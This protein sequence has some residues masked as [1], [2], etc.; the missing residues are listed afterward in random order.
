MW[1]ILFIA[2]TVADP[3]RATLVALRDFASALE[4]VSGTRSLGI[5]LDGFAYHL[6]DPRGFPVS[7]PDQVRWLLSVP[8]R[9]HH[10]S[11]HLVGSL[12][13]L[14]NAANLYHQVLQKELN[15]LALVVIR[16]S[17]AQLEDNLSIDTLRC[18]GGDPSMIAF[19]L[20][21][22][23][24]LKAETHL[25][26]FE[27]G[28]LYRYL[29][30]NCV[31]WADRER[32]HLAIQES[33][34]RL[35]A[36]GPTFLDPAT[37]LLRSKTQTHNWFQDLEISPSRIAAIE[38]GSANEVFAQMISPTFPRAMEVTTGKR[39]QRGEGG[40]AGS[41]KRSAR[42]AASSSEAPAEFTLAT[43]ND[44]KL[45]KDGHILSN[46]ATWLKHAHVDLAVLSE[47]TTNTEM[48]SEEVGCS[49][50]SYIIR[51]PEKTGR[52]LVGGVAIMWRSTATVLEPTVT[53]PTNIHSLGM[54]TFKGVKVI[55]LYIRPGDNSDDFMI[56]ALFETMSDVAREVG[57]GPTIVTG[58][59]NCVT[60]SGRREVLESAMGALGLTLLNRGILSYRDHTHAADLDLIFGSRDVKIARIRTAPKIRTNDHERLVS[61][62]VV[63]NKPSLA[64]DQLSAYSIATSRIAHEWWEWLLAGEEGESTIPENVGNNVRLIFHNK[65][66]P[67]RSPYLGW[68]QSP[69][70][71]F[72]CEYLP[73][74]SLRLITNPELES[75]INRVARCPACF[76]V[77]NSILKDR[78]GLRAALRESMASAMKFSAVADGFS[79]PFVESL[80]M[81]VFEPRIAIGNSSNFQDEIKAAAI[82]RIAIERSNSSMFAFSVDLSGLNLG[83][84]KDLIG[85][86]L[87]ADASTGLYSL[88]A[89][90]EAGDAGCSSACDGPSCV[91]QPTDHLASSHRPRF[92][93]ATRLGSR[94]AIKTKTIQC[95]NDSPL[96]KM[97][98]SLLLVDLA[99]H[100]NSIGTAYS[101]TYPSGPKIRG[102]QSFLTQELNAVTWPEGILVFSPDEATMQARFRGLITWMRSATGQTLAP[103]DVSHFNLPYSLE[104]TLTLDT[105]FAVAAGHSVYVGMEISSIRGDTVLQQRPIDLVKVWYEVGFHHLNHTELADPNLMANTFRDFIYPAMFRGFPVAVPELADWNEFW[106]LLAGHWIKSAG[107]L[108][109]A[110]ETA[111]RK[112]DRFVP[113][114]ILSGIDEERRRVEEQAAMQDGEQPT[115]RRP[116]RGSSRSALSPLNETEVFAVLGWENHP[117]LYAAEKAA[118]FLLMEDSTDTWSNIIRQSLRDGHWVDQL[119]KKI[120]RVFA[121]ELCVANFT[122]SDSG[123][124]AEKARAPTVAAESFK[125]GRLRERSES[126]SISERSASAAERLAEFQVMIRSSYSCKVESIIAKAR[127]ADLTGKGRRSRS[128]S[129]FTTRAMKRACTDSVDEEEDDAEF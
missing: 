40:A 58:D 128:Q 22:A 67:I 91:W 25:Y 115:G 94:P 53:P 48:A 93:Q 38:R 107:I 116:P 80:L 96:R 13:A 75:G 120:F 11:S 7:E 50:G 102:K 70:F 71:D 26:L 3:S 10:Q 69:Q 101:L 72:P 88:A 62:V 129:L 31:I 82:A 60:G 98:R 109:E 46:L 54:A 12:S 79:R 121:P 85:R 63:V 99:A 35:V 17:A 68:S 124:E 29:M 105:G 65:D 74:F 78:V 36:K 77:S 110:L 73:G 1:F 90:L 39:K 37:F 64:Q 14:S 104:T 61:E 15:P 32:V 34:I 106:T 56:S 97:I 81:D 57:T 127:T 117:A 123:V 30:K 126:I 47:G 5:S 83:R 59:M 20:L 76:G 18:V 49:T 2:L 119:D 66:D 44:G 114:E 87:D 45:A 84:A 125:S 6:D 112:L 122:G 95:R 4:F 33:V 23:A 51:S 21:I 41:R 92:V 89:Y 24:S 9:A 52:C 113:E 43:I 111:V 19:K 28:S 27:L 86:L 16:V 118:K 103:E 42:G 8:A 108:G 55:G 100:L